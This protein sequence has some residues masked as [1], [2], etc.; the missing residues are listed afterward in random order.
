MAVN[1]KRTGYSWTQ[2]ETSPR[3][4]CIGIRNTSFFTSR[5]RGFQIE[6]LGSLLLMASAVHGVNKLGKMSAYD[7]MYRKCCTI[8]SCLHDF[9]CYCE[10]N[11]FFCHCARRGPQS[12]LPKV[13][14]PYSAI[15]VYAIVRMITSSRDCHCERK[16]PYFTDSSALQAKVTSPKPRSQYTTS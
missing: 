4:E 12:S 9:L 3:T 2:L 5:R 6:C 7:N 10:E 1:T 11:L 16:R 15:Y 8:G 14:T 13:I